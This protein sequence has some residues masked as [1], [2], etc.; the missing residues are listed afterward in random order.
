MA[1]SGKYARREKRDEPP[2]RTGFF[3]Q[4]L[5]NHIRLIAAVTTVVV[6]LVVA[7]TVEAI[8][9]DGFAPEGKKG[10]PIPMG[11]LNALSEKTAPISWEDLNSYRY[12]TL[13]ESE[14]DDGIYVLRRYE[15]EGGVLSVMV[16]GY[17]KGDAFTGYVA[18][19]DVKHIDDFDFSFSLLGGGDLSAYLAEWEQKK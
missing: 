3:G 5:D 2:R 10:K 18:Y 11:A 6:L 9:T 7:F 12:E 4:L 8:F 1:Y 15:V 13:S 19:A 17:V 14:N 16:G